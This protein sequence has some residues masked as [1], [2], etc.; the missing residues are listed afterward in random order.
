MTNEEGGS[1]MNYKWNKN[2]KVVSNFKCVCFGNTNLF[3]TNGD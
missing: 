3:T 1:I 2:R